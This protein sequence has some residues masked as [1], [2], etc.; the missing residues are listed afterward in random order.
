MEI[1]S[2]DGVRSSTPPKGIV[3]SRGKKA[4]MRKPKRPQM[5]VDLWAKQRDYALSVKKLCEAHDRTSWMVRWL[6][7]SDDAASSVWASIPDKVICFACRYERRVPDC[8]CKGRCK[9]RECPKCGRKMP[10]YLGLVCADLK[11][12]AAALRNGK[13]PVGEEG[14]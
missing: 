11:L 14:R 5:R 4:W 6:T 3:V 13:I 9:C 7:S 1:L 12:V 8:R 10:T 2:T